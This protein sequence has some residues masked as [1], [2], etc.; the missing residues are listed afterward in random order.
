MEPRQA[1]PAVLAALAM[2]V[3]ASFPATIDNS[4]TPGIGLGW[5]SLERGDGPRSALLL[6]TAS[7]ALASLRVTQW[8]LPRSHGALAWR[9]MIATIPAFI[10][11]VAVQ[12][13]GHLRAPNG[14]REAAAEAVLLVHQGCLLVE[15]AGAAMLVNGAVSEAGMGLSTGGA[16]TRV[17]AG[18]SVFVPAGS[19]IHAV[20]ACPADAGRPH[21]ADLGEGERD[22]GVKG[23]RRVSKRAVYRAEQPAAPSRGVTFVAVRYVTRSV[24]R[25]GAHL[26]PRS[27]ALPLMSTAVVSAPLRYSQSNAARRMYVASLIEGRSASLQRV[28]V[29]CN[30]FPLGTALEPHADGEYD[31]LVLLIGGRV[32]DL[33]PAGGDELGPGALM[34]SRRG[35]LHGFRVVDGDPGA[36]LQVIELEAASELD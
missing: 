7:A 11:P 25:S 2:V 6:D 31:A 35:S 19:S 16:S 33:A 32:R 28:R 12:P 4:I 34:F 9:R 24:A 14:T 36:M 17:E 10:A 26:P 5:Q 13:W 27:V 15:H 18:G 21:A 22:G 8:W 20:R 1:R 30:S 29:H 23:R 3:R